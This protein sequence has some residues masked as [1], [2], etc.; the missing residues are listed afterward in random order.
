MWTLVEV[1]N[2][3]QTPDIFLYSVKTSENLVFRGSRKKQVARNGLMRG[4]MLINFVPMLPEYGKA[5]KF[6]GQSIQEW[7][8]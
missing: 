4:T 2:P 6:M 3:F 5:L 7:T 1:F 8:K